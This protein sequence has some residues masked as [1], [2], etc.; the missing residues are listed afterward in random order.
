MSF[1]R[2][3]RAGVRFV[4]WHADGALRYAHAVDLLKSREYATASIL[5]VGSGSLGVSLFLDRS[6]VGY[7]VS[8]DG[9]DLGL[10]RRVT[11]ADGAQC[12]PFAD[13]SFDV[14]LSMDMLEHIPETHREHTVREMMRVARKCVLV[15][16][17]CGPEAEKG[18][19]E[20]YEWCRT[21]LRIDY[22]WPRE[23]M[24]LGLPDAA[25]IERC[26]QIG[27]AAGQGW[28]LHVHDSL[29]VRVWL[30]IWR[31]Q[32]SRSKIWRSVKNKMLWPLTPWLKRK[33]EHPVYRK[34]FVLTRNGLAAEGPRES[35]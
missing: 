29:N 5:E 24:A 15:T 25:E 19:R 20:L 22:R 3:L 4:R 9:P 7:D 14:V 28:R 34:V 21:K 32:M 33:N 8:F 18:D 6:F 16:V 12:L 2:L 30:W 26:F 11:A 17:P 1:S 31:F 27:E 23:H 10:M 35:I 13:Q